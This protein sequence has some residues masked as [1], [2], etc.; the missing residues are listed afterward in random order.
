MSKRWT[1][2]LLIIFNEIKK[3]EDT[4]GNYMEIQNLCMYV[5]NLLLTLSQTNNWT[6]SYPHVHLTRASKKYITTIII[7]VYQLHYIRFI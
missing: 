5:W 4:E 6:L 3:Q 2:T 7:I 1:V